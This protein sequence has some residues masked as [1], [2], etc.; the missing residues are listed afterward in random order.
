MRLDTWRLTGASALFF[1]TIYNPEEAKL[2]AS[3]FYP[4]SNKDVFKINLSPI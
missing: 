1:Y 4:T 3:H 2:V